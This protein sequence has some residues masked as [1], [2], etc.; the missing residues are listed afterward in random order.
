ML[1]PAQSLMKGKECMKRDD[2]TNCTRRLNVSCFAGASITLLLLAYGQVISNMN[3]HLNVYGTGGRGY[4]DPGMSPELH[5]PLG[6][7]AWHFTFEWWPIA[8][9]AT[10][11]LIALGAI[12]G[13]QQAKS[14]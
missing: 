7:F 5:M 6:N 11:L 8:F 10:L 12:L 13:N 1:F 9:I 2:D 3:G 4:I 14:C